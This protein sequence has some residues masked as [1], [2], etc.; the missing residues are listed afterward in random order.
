[1]GMDGYGNRINT[2]AVN[3]A[4]RWWTHDP[5]IATQTLEKIFI[6]IPL[7]SH[8]LVFM[9]A[10]YALTRRIMSHFGYQFN[11]HDCKIASTDLVNA[12]KQQFNRRRG[13]YQVLPD[14]ATQ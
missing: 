14:T 5:S 11:P 7:T 9:W 8:I 2:R 4:V 13:S 1:M 10:G 6:I 3:I 12:V